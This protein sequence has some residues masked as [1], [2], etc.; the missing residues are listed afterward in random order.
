MVCRR[1]VANFTLAIGYCLQ[2]RKLSLP[3]AD[4]GKD[5]DY[6]VQAHHQR[7]HRGDRCDPLEWLGGCLAHRAAFSR[8]M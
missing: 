6:L 4:L 3:L 1:G 8:A 7:D 5:P 2:L